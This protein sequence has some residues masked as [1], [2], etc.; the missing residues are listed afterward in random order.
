MENLSGD[1]RSIV[2]RAILL[3]A[4]GF[5]ISLL[6]TYLLKKYESKI[7]APVLAEKKWTGAGL[8]GSLEGAIIYLFLPFSVTRVF[9][10]VFLA[11]IFVSVFI[12]ARA[13][14]I[15]NSHD[16]SRIVIDEWAGVWVALWGVL[17][18]FSLSFVLAVVFFRLFD[19]FKGPIGR[20]CQNMP[21]GWGITLDDVYAGFAAN[22]LRRVVVHFI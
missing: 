2:D 11:M 8:F 6:P 4:T 14:K 5:G 9:L 20:R 1:Q 19:V 3:L 12:S 16:D 17:P 7:N 15:L 18:R 13:E 21:G 22:I 10:L